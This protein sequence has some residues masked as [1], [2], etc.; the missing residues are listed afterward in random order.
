MNF[1]FYIYIKYNVV[2]EVIYC[3]KTNEEFIISV[4]FGYVNVIL[5][6]LYEEVV[7]P[8]VLYVK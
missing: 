5:Q 3:A 1:A 7:V 2:C 6:I 8:L 4:L